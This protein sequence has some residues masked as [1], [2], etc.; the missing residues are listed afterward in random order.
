MNTVARPAGP[1]AVSPPAPVAAADCLSS[2]DVL[3]GVAVLGILLM[4]IVLFA[5]PHGVDEDPTL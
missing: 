5:L 1:E 2:V 4:N 3:R